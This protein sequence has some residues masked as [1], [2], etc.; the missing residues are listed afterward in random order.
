MKNFS[1]LFLALA[2]LTLAFTSPVE[3]VGVDTNTSVITWKGYKVLGSHTGTI[4]INTGDLQ[5]QDGQLV[6]GSFTIDMKTINCTDLEGEYKGKLEGH[7]KSADFFG[8]DKY[9][10]AN[11][12]ITSV[13]SRGTPGAYKITGD[14]KIKETTKPI[15]FNVNIGE[16]GGQQV[17]TGDVQIDRSDFDI[18]YGSGSFFDNLGDNTIYDEFD[19]S[20]RLVLN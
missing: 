15:R 12:N 9:P 16:E 10:T 17:A 13:V 4:K 19:L 1:I 6:G 11:F 3:T 2:A 7:L 8:V 14:L 18:R 5:M 20:I